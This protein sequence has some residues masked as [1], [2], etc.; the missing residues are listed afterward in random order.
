MTVLQAVI[1]L[2]L[3]TLLLSVI[4]VVCLLAK[5]ALDAAFATLFIAGTSYALTAFSQDDSINFTDKHL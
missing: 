5:V 2:F 3:F 1:E 4:T